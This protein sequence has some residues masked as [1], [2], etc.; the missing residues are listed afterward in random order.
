MIHLGGKRRPVPATQ[1]ILE[2]E[3][4]YRRTKPVIRSQEFCYKYGSLI[5]NGLTG[6]F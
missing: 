2:E 6:S 4:T 1:E 3:T 5:L